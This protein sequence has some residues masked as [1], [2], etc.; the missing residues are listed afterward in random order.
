MPSIVGHA[1][2]IALWM[3]IV[4]AAAAARSEEPKGNIMSYGQT[5]ELM[6]KHAKI[7]EL[8][9]ADGSA[10]VAVVPAWQ[11]RVMTSTNAG[12]DGPSFVFVHRD[13]IEA[14]KPDV[15]FNNYGG[16][17]RF[18]LCPEGGQFSL[19]FKPGDKQ[20]LKNWRTP[21]AL[22]EGEWKAV[23][24]EEGAI[25]LSADL[26]F[27]NT[28]NTPFELSVR[29]TVSLLSNDRL[30][31]LFG[32]PAAKIFARPDVQT[33]AYETDNRITN[34]GPD[35]SKAKGLVSIW[36]LGMMNSSPKTVVLVP[37]KRGDEAELGPVVKSD[38]FGAIPA[39]RLL[40]TPEAVLFRAD[41]KYRSKIGTSQ[42]RARNVVGSIDFDAGVL[43]LVHFTM[44]EDP[45]KHD[46]INNMWEVPQVHP[47][48]G[49]VVNSYNDG[50]NE[51][52]K[53]LGAFYEI[54]TISPAKT[55]K[56]GESLAHC[57]RTVHVRADAAALRALAREVLGVDLDAVRRAMAL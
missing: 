36:I 17:D 6:K 57:H 21:P 46:Y 44:P 15:Q 50:P 11:G 30:E 53:Q 1:R 43:T 23:R 38:Y 37:Y 32:E 25:S 13:F 52:G 42:R 54:E 2:R 39:D 5:L 41:A 33:V 27:R 14:G 45:A 34:L 56:T 18:W 10:R 22:N 49:D 19:W 48:I 3:L 12:M 29:R 31:E 24:D 40:V 16:E 4:A 8:T 26:K 20:E 28:A 9:N 35:F 47:F 51:L 55:L 7:V